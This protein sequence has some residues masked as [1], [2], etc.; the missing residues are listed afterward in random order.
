MTGKQSKSASS[1]QGASSIWSFNLWQKLRTNLLLGGMIVSL[2]ACGFTP[3][4]DE[5]NGRPSLDAMLARIEAPDNVM[6]RQLTRTLESGLSG[7]GRLRLTISLSDTSNGLIYDPT[8]KPERY[9]IEHRAGVAYY[10][11]ASDRTIT[12]TYKYADSYGVDD[13]E[14]VN[15]AT[16]ER[17]R[18]LAVRQFATDI[19]RALPQIIALMDAP[20]GG[21]E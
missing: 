18:D 5:R 15:L 8:G 17:I 3:I 14:A 1:C 7:A 20:K 9:L 4:Y 21:T 16:R 2:A 6:G 12:K 11:A 10:D 13:N 19:R